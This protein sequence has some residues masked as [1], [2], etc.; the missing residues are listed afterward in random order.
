MTPPLLRPLLRKNA[1]S[2]FPGPQAKSLSTLSL[3]P[4]F[5]IHKPSEGIR[6]LSLQPL[7]LPSPHLGT[8]HPG[9][10][11]RTLAGGPPCPPELSPPRCHFSLP[12]GSRITALLCSAPSRGS[13]VTTR[14]WQRSTGPAARPPCL[15]TVPLQ[16]QG[17]F[18]CSSL[19]LGLSSQRQPHGSP[20]A[21]FRSLLGG[22]RI[23]GLP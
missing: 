2:H 18:T 16:P 15:L 12:E 10:T 3:T 17:L 19:C 21:Y 13:R 20:L 11:H 4:P 1:T 14:S 22:E 9:V 6:I 7:R 8:P 23:R 5:L